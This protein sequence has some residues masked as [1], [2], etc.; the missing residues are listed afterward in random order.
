MLQE[1]WTR[2]GPDEFWLISPPH[3]VSRVEWVD[4]RNRYR[5]RRLLD[6]ASFSAFDQSQQGL[7][8]KHIPRAT[9]KLKS[10][11]IDWWSLYPE[12]GEANRAPMQPAPLAYHPTYVAGTGPMMSG[13]YGQQG[14]LVTA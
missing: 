14:K 9:S 12:P 3:T 1:Y 4:K 6:L 10:D 8:H 7:K 11:S 5:F 13:P 2:M